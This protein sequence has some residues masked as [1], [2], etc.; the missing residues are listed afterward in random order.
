M[1]MD[2]HSPL[3]LPN[4]IRGSEG[5]SDPNKFSGSNFIVGGGSSGGDGVGTSSG[6][7]SHRG[8]S[9]SNTGISTANQFESNVE[10]SSLPLNPPLPLRG[11]TPPHQHSRGLSRSGTI[12]VESL[13]PMEINT[14]E[15]SSSTISMIVGYGVPAASALL[16]GLT[17]SLFQDQNWA[18]LL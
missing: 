16:R 6:R 4:R 3:A 15:P 7:G 18:R 11:A 9:S 12:A 17:I 10:D 5:T 13:V 2:F 8:T 1:V 14:A